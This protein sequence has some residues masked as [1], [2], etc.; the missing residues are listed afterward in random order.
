MVRFVTRLWKER[1]T[2]AIFCL[3]TRNQHLKIHFLKPCK[4]LKLSS[5]ASASHL[6][7]LYRFFKEFE[8]FIS[9]FWIFFEVY[10]IILG[11]M[12]TPRS[13]LDTTFEIVFIFLYRPPIGLNFIDHIV[14]NVPDREMV[15]VTEW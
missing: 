6:G 9:D 5:A 15:P 10:E 3:G 7:I 2:K 13:T 4:C 14:G 12:Y 1:I 8:G 11:A